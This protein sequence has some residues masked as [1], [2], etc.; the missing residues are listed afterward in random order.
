MLEHGRSAKILDDVANFLCL[1]SSDKKPYE[2]ILAKI[3]LD[4]LN[5]MSDLS[6]ANH[7]GKIP[8]WS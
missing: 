5:R 2:L 8:A 1:E 4:K 6:G 3:R 7:K